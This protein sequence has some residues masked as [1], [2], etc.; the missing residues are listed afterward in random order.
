MRRITVIKQIECSADAAWHALHNPEVAAQLY[1]PLLKMVPLSDKGFKE[2]FESDTR[3]DVALRFVGF[4]TVGVQRISI[5]DRVSGSSRTMRDRGRPLKGP[6][7]LLKTWNHEIT[8]SPAGPN[9]SVWNDQLTIGG[10][11]APLAALVIKPMWIWRASK[12]A[13]LAKDWVVTS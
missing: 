10:E 13:R 2:R 12:I 11:F 6:L 5:V 7:A 4:I 9:Q 3:V 1:R 8:I